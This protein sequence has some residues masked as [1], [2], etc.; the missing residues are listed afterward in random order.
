MVGVNPEGFRIMANRIFA[1]ALQARATLTQMKAPSS[2]RFLFRHFNE[3]LAPH[4]E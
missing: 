2:L 4:R 3:I 1:F